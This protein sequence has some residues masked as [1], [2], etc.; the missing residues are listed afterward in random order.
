MLKV[1]K[2][3]GIGKAGAG[4]GGLVNL[5]SEKTGKISFRRSLPILLITLIAAPDIAAHGLA[6]LNV[7]VIGIAAA[8]YVL[9]QIIEKNDKAE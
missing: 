4:N 6:V 9:P 2:F 5:I 3:L 7:I 8:I 1:A